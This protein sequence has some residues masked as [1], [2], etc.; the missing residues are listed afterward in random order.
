MIF[1]I[2]GGFCTSCGDGNAIISDGEDPFL[3]PND[4]EQH[5]A[6][7]V[8]DTVAAATADQHHHPDFVAGT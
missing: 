4:M 5:R 6:N 1:W 3:F 2:G 8:V 7:L